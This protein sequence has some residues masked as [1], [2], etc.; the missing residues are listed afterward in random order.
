MSVG[1]IL[2]NSEHIHI[3]IHINGREWFCLNN[4]ELSG[5]KG[6]RCHGIHGISIDDP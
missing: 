2:N 5:H 3:I 6:G 4:L 1:V